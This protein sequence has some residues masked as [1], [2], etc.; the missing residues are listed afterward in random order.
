MYSID[1]CYNLEFKDN[2]GHK[3]TINEKLLKELEED[4]LSSFPDGTVLSNEITEN[5]YYNLKFKDN[6]QLKIFKFPVNCKFLG[7]NGYIPLYSYEH[8]K[9][10]LEILNF[11]CPFYYSAFYKQDIYI[12]INKIEQNYFYLETEIEIKDK[13]DD[14]SETI[15]KIFQDFKEIYKEEN[16]SKCTYKFICPTFNNY[17]YN[18]FI[19]NLSDKFDYIYTNNR[20]LLEGRILT[21]LEGKDSYLYPICGP[22]GT[23][24]TITSLIIHKSFYLKGIKGIYL[25]LKY[26]ANN[27]ISWEEKI[28]VLI[29]ECFFIINNEKELIDFYQEFVKL[30]DIDEAIVVIKNFIEKQDNIYMIIDQYKSNY[31]KNQ[32]LNKLKNIKIFLLSSIN[33]FDVKNNLIFKYEEE[34]QEEF[35]LQNKINIKKESG[36]IKYNYIENLVDK[37]YYENDKFKNMIKTKIKGYEKDEKKVEI[38]FKSIYNILKNFNF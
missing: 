8:L 29:K 25:N 22:H 6:S 31:N 28:D 21:F 20:K 17:L 16:K 23:G 9:K 3:I 1:N 4:D 38:E 37:D 32:I 33:D 30:K 2:S 35:S 18:K 5:Y 14:Y 10:V 11:N 13:K 12:D 34:L 15:K 36:I 24:K 19:I 26:Y 7:S 27:R